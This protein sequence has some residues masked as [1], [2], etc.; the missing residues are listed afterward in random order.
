MYHDTRRCS[1]S[2]VRFQVQ[3]LRAAVTDLVKLGDAPHSHP[4]ESRTQ[5]RNDR[6]QCTDGHPDDQVFL[7][8]FSS[9]CFFEQLPFRTNKTLLLMQGFESWGFRERGQQRFSHTSLL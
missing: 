4:P 1:G 6:H 9:F 5:R 7:A 8:L 3:S 2:G